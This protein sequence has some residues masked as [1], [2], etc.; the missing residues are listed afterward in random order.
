MPFKDK[1]SR[2]EY[3]LKHKNKELNQMKAYRLANP[4]YYK[5]SWSN[6]C[7]SHKK[8]INNYQKKHNQEHPE[9]NRVGQL[10]RR[11]IP[12]KSKCQ[13]CGRTRNL[14]RAHFDYDKPLDDVYTFCTKCHSIIDKVIVP[15][16]TDPKIIKL[17][18][19][20]D[21]MVTFSL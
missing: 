6:Y 19:D 12:L 18:F 20:N 21:L 13:I 8:Q 11:H 3:Y 5:N 14:T 1:I 7:I 17:L 10:A 9:I 2:H 16:I 4:N 15:N